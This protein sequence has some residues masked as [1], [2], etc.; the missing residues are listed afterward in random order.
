MSHPLDHAKSSALR[1]GG[2]P[3]DYLELHAWF[4]ASKEHLANFRHRALRHH[5][6]GIFEAERVFGPTI[7]NT[8]GKAI[9]T[10]VLGEQHVREDCGR[11][12]TLADWLGKIPGERWMVG[13]VK[14]ENTPWTDGKTI[15]MD[16]FLAEHERMH[17][18]A[19]KLEF[20]RRR[21]AAVERLISLHLETTTVGIKP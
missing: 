20:N 14:L 1:H 6:Q 15:S 10:R 7:T 17:T 19:Q 9:P 4:D 12:P 21:D 16:G 8:E 11:I 18:A 13:N 3:E 5:S 2:V